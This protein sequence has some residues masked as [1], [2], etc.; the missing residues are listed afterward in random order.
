[1]KNILFFLF[2]A[3]FIS[4]CKKEENN[5]K[6]SELPFENDNLRVEVISE[7]APA[8]IRDMQFFNANEGLAATYDNKIYRTENAGAEW[9]IVYKDTTPNQPFTDILITA[10]NIGYAIGGSFSCS[11]TGCTPPGGMILKTIDKGKTWKKI[12]QMQKA[13]FSSIALNNKGEL[14]VTAIGPK[15][16]V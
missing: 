8:N 7:N 9:E 6:E 4:S 1:M 10:P 12:F 14:F 11:G 3:L 5:I 2:F 16:N 13:E 15:V